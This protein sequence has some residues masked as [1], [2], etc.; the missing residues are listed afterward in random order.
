[1][2]GVPGFAAG[3]SALQF[4][5]VQMAC[6]KHETFLADGKTRAGFFLGDGASVADLSC[7]RDS[8]LVPSMCRMLDTFSANRPKGLS[9]CP[10]AQCVLNDAAMSLALWCRLLDDIH[11]RH[12]TSMTVLLPCARTRRGQ[13]PSDCGAYP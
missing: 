10:L 11:E 4:Q 1:L 3:I 7:R 12:R 9:R 5:A 8:W 2:L 13:G 6:A